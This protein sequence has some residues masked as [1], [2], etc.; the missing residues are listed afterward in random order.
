[1]SQ[2]S[3]TPASATQEKTFSSYNKEQG[4]TYAQ[5]RPD[6]SPGV[7]HVVLDQHKA[8]SGELDTLIDLGCGPGN[9]AR[10][11]GVHFAHAIGLDPSEGMIATARSLGGT[12]ST[13]EPIRYEVSTAEDIGANASPPIPDNS[14]DLITAANSAHWF[15]MSRFW[16]SAARVL[17]PGGSVAIWTSG[18]SR[19]HPSVP[20]AAAMQAEI[21][22]IEEDHL[23]PYFEPGNFLTR[24]HYTDLPLPW[25]LDPSVAGFEKSDFFRKDWNLDE[26]FYVTE[27]DV[28]LDMFEKMIG[29]TSPVTRWREANPDAVGTEK[30]VVR[31]FRRAIER[32]LHA[33]G[34]EKGKEMIRG[35]SCGVVLVVKKN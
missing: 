35:A 33:A 1:M 17:K 22:Q 8:S 29:T 16:P 28:P 15:D 14:V 2:Q 10:A 23:R 20:N 13:S 34:V 6:Y 3:A 30:D 4:K 25:T 19:I 18:G 24:G 9:V 31:L 7:Y 21:D 26:R 11:L 12:T 32:H 27:P 5:F